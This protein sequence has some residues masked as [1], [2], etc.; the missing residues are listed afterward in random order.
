MKPPPFEYHAAE[1]LPE[2]LGMLADYGQDAKVLAGGQSLL[3]LLSLRLARPAHLIDINGLQ[4]E[5]GQI[6]TW[7]GG[8][9][10]H[11]EIEHLETL[12]ISDVNFR[13]VGEGGA[14]AAPAAL[15][16]A[17]ED[18]LSPLGVKITEQWL[19]PSRILELTGAIT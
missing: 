19:P 15:T 16:N 12:P 7:D 1:T 18:A 8:E 10:P 9:V 4:A 5:I 2:A 3:P 11:I 17:I 6:Q 13:G 14:I